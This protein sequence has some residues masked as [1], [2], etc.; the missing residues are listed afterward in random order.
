[1]HPAALPVAAAAL[2]L[3][4][5]CGAT[6][7]AEPSTPTAAQAS[8]ATTGPDLRIGD[9]LDMGGLLSAAADPA[10]L[11]TVRCDEPH[12]AE[13]YAEQNAAGSDLDRLEAQAQQ[14]CSARFEDFTGEPY[15]ES[16]LEV[17]FL[18]PTE[19]SWAAGDRS[20]RCIAVSVD[21]PVE[22]SFRDA[23]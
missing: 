20:V 1:M 5:G 6:Q 16:T 21:G 12:D 4:A 7:A 11:V 8:A 22:T 2:L 15:G 9:C 19:E 23:G 3:L 10:S 14:F 18:R 17:T 13:I